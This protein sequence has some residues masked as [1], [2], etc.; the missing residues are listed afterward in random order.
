MAGAAQAA[1]DVVSVPLNVV[2]DGTRIAKIANSKVAFIG[3]LDYPPGADVSLRFGTGAAVKVTDKWS[4][5]EF[6]PPHDQGVY[7]VVPSIQAGELL[8]FVGYWQPCA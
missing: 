8:L 1:Y 4:G 7:F 6:D 3:L 2:T 5:V